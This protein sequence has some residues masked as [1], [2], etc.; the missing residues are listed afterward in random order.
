MSVIVI[1][2]RFNNYSGNVPLAVVKV[3]K[4]K[5]PGEVFK[6]FHKE[7][8]LSS[9]EGYYAYFEY[10]VASLKKAGVHASMD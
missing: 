6:Q 8:K 9:V 7:H 10:D 2:D 3:P 4:G 5:L 1:M